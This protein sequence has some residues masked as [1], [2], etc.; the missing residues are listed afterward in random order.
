MPHLKN[1]N[2][3][4]HTQKQLP[5]WGGFQNVTEKAKETDYI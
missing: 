4:K 2:K 3:L 5:G 1:T